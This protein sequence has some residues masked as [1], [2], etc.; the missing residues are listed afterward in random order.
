M[1]HHHSFGPRRH[2]GD[3]HGQGLPWA[4]E[5]EVFGGGRKR[6]GEAVFGQLVLWRDI[7][8]FPT[9]KNLLMVIYI[10]ARIL[11]GSHHQTCGAL[12]LGKS[13]RTNHGIKK[14]HVCWDLL[15]PEKTQVQHVHWKN[16]NCSGLQSGVIF[17][18]TTIFLKKSYCGMTIVCGP[19]G[20]FYFRNHTKSYLRPFYHSMIPEEIINQ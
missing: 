2:R 7:P 19:L 8:T 11:I 16:W 9:K 18:W 3:R 20:P 10:Y 4:D 5:D 17:K 12:W 14:H 13:S 1:K 6:R 15:G